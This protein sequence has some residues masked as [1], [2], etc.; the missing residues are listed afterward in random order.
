MSL[1]YTGR[2]HDLAGRRSEAIQV[3]KQVIDQYENEYAAGVAR[4]GLL[5]PYRRRQAGAVPS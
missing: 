2:V 3:Y 5:A 4:A 1:M